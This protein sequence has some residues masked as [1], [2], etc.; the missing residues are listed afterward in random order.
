[1]TCSPL[2]SS[3]CPSFDSCYAN[4]GETTKGG[5]CEIPGSLA[6]NK[7]CTGANECAPDLACHDNGSGKRCVRVCDPKMGPS[8]DCALCK[9]GYTSPDGNSDYGV[10]TF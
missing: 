9:P 6:R 3:P 1:M 4:P 10:C 7:N 5:L 8:M 2:D